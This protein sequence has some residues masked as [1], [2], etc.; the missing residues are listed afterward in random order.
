MKRTVI[1]TAML[2]GAVLGTVLGAPLGAQAD[3]ATQTYRDLIRPNGHAR[4]DATFE[5]ALDTCSRQTGG[6]RTFHD[7]PAYKKCMVGQGYRWKSLQ[8]AREPASRRPAVREQT[9][10]D[11]ETG[12]RATPFWADLGL[13]VRTFRVAPRRF[14][15]RTAMQ[16]MKRSP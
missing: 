9:W 2:L 11:P 8:V 16:P 3:T 1:T 15:P 13:C 12:S 10:I 5:A 4:S 6:K 14:P 7:T